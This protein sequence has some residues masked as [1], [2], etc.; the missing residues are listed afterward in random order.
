MIILKQDGGMNN[1][2]SKLLAKFN[3]ITLLSIFLL[4]FTTVNSKSFSIIKDAEIENLLYDYTRDLIEIGLNNRTSNIY[5]VSDPSIN[6]F[7][8]PSG[9]IY[10]NVGLL[11]YADKPNEVI[12]CRWNL[13][14]R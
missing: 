2:A 5:I 1:V 11:Y 9:D 13:M 14:K 8:V 4:I 12:H 6:A 3:K 7:V 10:I